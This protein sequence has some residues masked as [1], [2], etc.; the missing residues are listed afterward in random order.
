MA[1]TDVFLD[2]AVTANTTIQPSSG[3]VYTFK[4]GNINIATFGYF[5]ISSRNVP[6]IYGYQ[7]GTEMSAINLLQ[8]SEAG[9]TVYRSSGVALYNPSSTPFSAI[10]NANY[11]T[12]GY[13]SNTIHYT[14]VGASLT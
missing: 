9:V 5:T 14:L 8:F 1:V 11:V 13:F 7:G 3:T 10:S 4:R 12:I 2:G 6:W